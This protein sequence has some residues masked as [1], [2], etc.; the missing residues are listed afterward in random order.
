MTNVLITGAE[1]FVGSHLA[2]YLLTQP[3]VKLSGMVRNLARTPAIDDIRDSITLYQADIN[4]RE[5]TFHAISQCRPAKIF[6]LAGQAYVPEA[7]KNPL[8]TFK[9]NILGSLHI[10]EAVRA[11]VP[12]CSV[13]VVSS[14][15]VYGIVEAAKMPVDESFPID[16]HTPYSA[17]KACL[18][19]LTQQYRMTFGLDAVIARAFNHLGPGQS[20]M[21]AGSSFA[22]QI[23]EAKLGLREKKIFV[24]NLDN[25]RDFTD[26]R[27]VV[28]AYV[29][30]LERRREHGIFN[31]C[32]GRSVSMKD[33]LATMIRVSG[34]AMEVETD[35]NRFR[36]VD[37]PLMVGS[38]A[39][40]TAETGWT[41]SIPLEQ[42]LGD[43]LAYWERRLRS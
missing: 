20:E 9:T 29:A 42:T 25:K 30:M 40:L 22:K 17:S 31:V 32:S 7:V 6:H 8:E 39:R 4:D 21:F 34:V 24:G 13:L 43:L 27:D 19:L 11:G 12:E 18:D 10:L 36:S 1:G 3:D 28:R 16:P 5:R 37:N 15:E 23:V 33:L 14:G 38:H 41:P 2:R 26:V 35:P